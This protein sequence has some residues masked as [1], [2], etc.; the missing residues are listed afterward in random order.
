MDG[1]RTHDKFYLNENYKANPKEY[2]KM[3]KNEMEEDMDKLKYTG[4]RTSLF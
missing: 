1:K 4:G 3:V 2:Y